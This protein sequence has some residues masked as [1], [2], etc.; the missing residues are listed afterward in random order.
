MSDFYIVL[1]SNSNPNTH[2]QNTANKYTVSWEVPVVLKDL[3]KWKV[4]LTDMSYNHSTWSI[5]PGHA[6][7]LKHSYLGVKTFQLQV[8]IIYEMGSANYGFEEVS[9]DVPIIDFETLRMTRR[10]KFVSSKFFVLKVDKKS[11]A[12]TLGFDGVKL[13]LESVKVNDNRYEL[14]ATT[15]LAE[16][17][18]SASITVAFDTTFE[19][20]EV[21][22]HVF[23]DSFAYS[24]VRQFLKAM[25]PI[26]KNIVGDLTMSESNVIQITVDQI[27]PRRKVY[28]FEKN[29]MITLQFLNGFH[30]VLGFKDNSTYMIQLGDTVT[31][32]T[33]VGDFQPELYQGI[34]H[35]YIYASVCSPIQ[36]GN[37]RAPLLKTVWIEPS[38]RFAINEVRHIEF[39]NKMH[40]PVSTNT[41]NSIEVNI[42]LDSG[43]LIPFNTGSITSL[44]L[45]FKKD[46]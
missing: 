4:A 22:E 32:K 25:Q 3:T 36:V 1:P 33:I 39:E 37:I 14:A 41:F 34:T 46:V 31:T 13:Q 27:P 30:H 43:E 44:T 29:R 24:N 19:Y 38:K 18:G 40:V 21:K 7:Q 20:I 15:P 45:H 5:R 26:F 10:I 35:M 42:R 12:V 9:N 2:P 17:S 11:D 16:K 8:Y 28:G 23:K 6:I